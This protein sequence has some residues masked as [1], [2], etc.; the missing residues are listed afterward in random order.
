MRIVLQTLGSPEGK[1]VWAVAKFLHRFLGSP[2]V[3][4]MPAFWRFLL[5][6]FFILPFY[7]WGAARR[8]R[9]VWCPRERCSLQMAKTRALAQRL[10]EAL[11]QAQVLVESFTGTPVGD[12]DLF[13]PL[14]PHYADSSFGL[15]AGTRKNVVPPYGDNPD[16]VNALAKL[17]EKHAGTIKAE[18][19]ILSFHG[20]PADSPDAE[21]Y[22]AECLK[23]AEFFS[24][25]AKID[26]AK[27]RVGFQSKFGPK[28]WLSPSTK[29]LVRNAPVPAVLLPAGFVCDCIETVHELGEL[30]AGTSVKLLPCLNEDA[31]EIFKNMTIRLTDCQRKAFDNAVKSSV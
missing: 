1:S 9:K 5:L 25:A 8:Y 31:A 7:S 21:R 20:V 10:Q 24:V 26:P 29:S 11:P 22:R 30:T 2:Q 23:T 17:F 3:L 28:K 16:F 14:Y 19:V 12:A 4:R 27:I 18:Q 6:D 13:I 15:L